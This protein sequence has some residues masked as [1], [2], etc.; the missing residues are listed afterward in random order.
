MTGTEF[1]KAWSMNGESL[2]LYSKSTVE[3]VNLKPETIEFLTLA[4]L[5]KYAEPNLSFGENHNN[6]C[7]IQKLNQIFDFG[8]KFEKYIVIGSCYDGDFIAINTDDNN[9]IFWLDDEDIELPPVLFNSS[10][11]TLAESLVIFKEFENKV[12]RN[13]NNDMRLSW[14]FTDEQFDDLKQKL[15]SADPEAMKG[16][17]FWNYELELE[18]SLRNDIKNEGIEKYIL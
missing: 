3:G 12:I 17:T 14:N 9:K 4:G 7:G 8:P 11:F 16:D 18:L 5:P 13:N 15:T 10:V 6:I 2:S 1:N